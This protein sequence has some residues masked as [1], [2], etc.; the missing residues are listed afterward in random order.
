MS[1][2]TPKSFW[3]LTIT[4]GV[5]DYIDFTINGGSEM[6]ARIAAATYLSI[7]SLLTACETAM[8]GV[9]NT[10][11]Y[12]ISAGIND[13]IDFTLNGEGSHSATIAPGNYNGDDLAAA[14]GAAMDAVAYALNPA[15]GFTGALM[16]PA[17][18]YVGLIKGASTPTFSLQFATGPNHA[19]SAAAVLGFAATDTALAA[20]HIAASVPVPVTWTVTVSTSGRVTLATY[21]SWSLKFSTGTHAATSA[22]DVLGFGTVDTAA[23]TTHTGT[24]QHTNGWYAID[25]VKAETHDVPRFTRV[26]TRALEGQA[27]ALQYGSARYTRAVSLAFLPAYKVWKADEG[28][29]HINEAF[30]RWLE[31]GWAKFRWW[32]DASVEATYTDYQLDE[33]TAEELP[34]Q[35]HSPGNPLYSLNLGFLKYV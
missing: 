25:P 29:T 28:A 18:G 26:V 15:W 23:G 30:E 2:A 9:T 6:S 14:A 5:N 35:R 19:T 21:A 34:E 13:K 27:V 11:P 1:A 17:P 16:A 12:S 20:E 31:D 8:D 24:K 22:R 10:T 7:A 32:P 33:K 3:P 4:S